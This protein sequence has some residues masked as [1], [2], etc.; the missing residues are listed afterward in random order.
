[1]D[2]QQWM[3]M[4][5]MMILMILMILLTDECFPKPCQPTT[6]RQDPMGWG[7][8]GKGWSKGGWGDGKGAPWGQMA[9]AKLQRLSILFLP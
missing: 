3:M 2:D 4:M 9:Q 1:M 7:G 5:M 6:P 8:E